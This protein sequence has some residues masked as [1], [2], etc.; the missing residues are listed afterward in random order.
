MRS[1]ADLTAMLAVTVASKQELGPNLVVNWDFEGEDGWRF[2]DE[3]RR[4]Q[5]EDAPGG[6]HVL[7]MER[8]G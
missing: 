4:V 8:R 5:M 1:A 3:R 2:N 7:M 6:S